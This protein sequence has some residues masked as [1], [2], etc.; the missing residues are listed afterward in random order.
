MW[1]G[2]IIDFLFGL[3]GLSRKTAQEKLGQ[4]EEK[5]ATQSVVLS[6]VEKSHE[7]DIIDSKLSDDALRLQTARFRR[8]D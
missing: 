7:Q 3:I 1:I 5:S 8:P 2:A 4:A 6:E